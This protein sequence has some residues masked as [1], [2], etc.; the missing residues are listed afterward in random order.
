M[1]FALQSLIREASTALGSEACANGRHQ[2]ASI[3]GRACPHPDEVGDGRCSQ[4]VFE[5][6]TCGATDYGKRGGPGWHHCATECMQGGRDH[7]NAAA[8]TAQ[9]DGT[10]D[11]DCLDEHDYSGSPVCGSCGAGVDAL[12]SAECWACGE[13][14]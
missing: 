14:L 7:F 8:P 2:W 12:Y 4:A 9:N 5:C 13:E 11:D 10:G 3:G 6:Q 1:T